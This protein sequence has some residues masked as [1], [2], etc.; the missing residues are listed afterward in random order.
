MN[1]GE[2]SFL[3]LFRRSRYSQLVLEDDNSSEGKARHE[4]RERFVVAALAFCLKHDGE[5]LKHFWNCICRASGDP[6]S[7]PS[8][9]PEGISLEPPLWSDLRLESEHKGLG[10]VWVIEVKAG[11][12]L[13]PRQ[14]PD[15]PDFKR[16][17]FG[18]GALLSEYHKGTDTRRRYVI[19]GASE[20]DNLKIRHN[21]KPFGIVVDD[22]KWDVLATLS[23][24]SGIVADLFGTLG[25]IGD[26]SLPYGKC[27][28]DPC[29][30]RNRANL[31]CVD[32][33]DRRL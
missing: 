23:K 27:E 24:R 10:Y 29:S 32:C 16:P 5:F 26:Q 7:M 30:F 14:R 25:E 19:L 2:P 6:S 18:Y 9:R 3:R 31:Q 28:K 33:S 13:K 4:Q 1:P 17:G 22:R 20:S 21:E 12:P 15:R 8:I 11:A